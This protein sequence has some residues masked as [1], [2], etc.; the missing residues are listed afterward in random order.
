MTLK[1]I[2]VLTL[3]VL[4]VA[5]KDKTE[6]NNIFKFKDYISYTTS[7]VVSVA[8][9]IQ[10]NLAKEVEGWEEEQELTDK[11]ISI[12]PHV[13]GKLSVANKHTLIFIPNE[14]LEPDT[15]YTVNVKLKDIYQ[16]IPN[17][18]NTYTFQ[19][20]T[21]APGFNVVTNNL[22]SYSKEWQYLNA[23]IRSADIISLEKAKQLV[24]ATQNGK[25]LPLSFDEYNDKA[26]IFE[27]K[28]DSIS[29]QIEDSDITVKWNG[30]AIKADNKGENTILIPGKNNF[31]IVDV[32]VVQSPEQYLS[33]NF[34]DPLKKQ[35]NFDGLVTLQDT[36]NPKFIVDGNV[37]KVYPNTRLTGNISVDVFQG[38][39]SNDGFKLKKAFSEVITFEELKPQ[40]RLINNGSILP[41][42]KELKFNFE[43]VNLKAVDVRVIKI[44][45]DN[46]LQLLQDYNLNGNIYDIKKVGRRIAKQTIELQTES[47]NTG[48]WKAY[49]I[50][51][52]KF[53]QADAGAIY[54]VELSF[55]R[56]YSLY[57]CDSKV[58][59]T[60]NEEETYN[61][62]YDEDVDYEDNDL[63]EE[64][65]WDNLTYRYKN[66]TYNWREENNPCHDA[67]YG[68]SKIV[69]Q[70]LLASNL[71]VIAKQ[72]TNGAYYFAVTNILSTD[73]EANAMVKLYNYQQQEIASHPTDNE[74]LTL[75]D[76]DKNAAFAIVT[77][78]NNST[79]LKLNDGS[80]LSLST[81][82]ISGNRLQ[83]GLKGYIYGE[84]G[85]WRPGD[86]LHLNFML[87]DSANPLPKGH[88]VKMEITDPSGKLVY[89]NITTDNLDNLYSFKVSTT[90]EDKTGNYNA[91]V[92]VGGATFDK[93]LRIETVNPNR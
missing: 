86:T 28:I 31:T 72:G 48:K 34:S 13:E 41:N 81:F 16:D 80:S 44:F 8:E 37:L 60:S 46:I 39:T 89:K 36:K 35:Q 40:V 33:L 69:S 66:Y 73:P 5:C 12:K 75:F 62:Y 42:S 11:L 24:E 56:S 83:R 2:L 47:E 21:I 19:F 49:S 15:E 43:A 1:R 52:S 58:S 84:R 67:Y 14:Y 74:G 17:D 9:S 50:D 59:S 91:K 79:Y 88:P 57:N 64:A 93:T 32:D 30:S 18:F 76:T 20:K 26:K 85:V 70:N 29:R 45:Q 77:K 38:I 54:R 10:I 25:K 92:S 6:P 3:I 27:F 82:D 71:G 22:Q 90:P 7:G 78:G 53:F 87:N 68:E 23:V 4:V 63:R 61:D 65:Y 55:N 51:L